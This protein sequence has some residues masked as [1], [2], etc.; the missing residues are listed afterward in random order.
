MNTKMYVNN[1]RCIDKCDTT[2]MDPLFYGNEGRRSIYMDS[3]RK[4]K[5]GD[6]VLVKIGV[7][8][9]CLRLLKENNK[10]YLVPDDENYEREELLPSDV[11]LVVATGVG[12]DL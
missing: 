3:D 9:I 6:V 5:S 11:I 8:I 2:R 1:E 4:P 7:K 10:T 12:V